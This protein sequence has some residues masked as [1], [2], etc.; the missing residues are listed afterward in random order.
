MSFVN[1][2]FNTEASLRELATD[3]QTTSNYRQVESK[4][5]SS[6]D[7]V[8]RVY[9]EYEEHVDEVPDVFRDSINNIF[10]ASIELL[11]AAGAGITE[12]E[13]N[14]VVLTED[15]RDTLHKLDDEVYNLTGKHCVYGVSS[16]ASSVVNDIASC[17]HRTAE[18][19]S[20]AIRR[21]EKTVG[22]CDVITPSSEGEELCSTWTS[23]VDENR[24]EDLYINED[25][26]AL[27]GWVVGRKVY[28][29]VGS[30]EGHRTY[31]DFESGKLDY[32]DTDVE[33]NKVIKEMLTEAG[34]SCKYLPNKEGVECTGVDEGKIKPIAAALS[35][36]TSMDIRISDNA[37]STKADVVT[38][39]VTEFSDKIKDP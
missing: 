10:N 25:Y 37:S 38:D 9:D 24:E 32:Y 17:L 2:L 35:L 30:S 3:M 20:Q 39:V 12:E 1:D 18:F 23:F 28:L 36:A 34:L 11:D 29:R 27:K 15:V 31:V 16:K 19:L 33:V 14:G 21:P 26:S 13:V 7:L 22:F 5:R 8:R 4:Y 6:V